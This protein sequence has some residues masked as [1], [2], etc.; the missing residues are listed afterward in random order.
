MEYCQLTQRERYAMANM[1]HR[2]Y[3]YRE[4]ARVLDRSVSTISRE[5]KRNMTHHDGR[6]RAEKAH[7]YAMARRSRTRRKSQY[8]QQEWAEVARLLMRKWSP[9]QIAGRARAMRTS[10]M[11]KETIYRYVKRERSAGGQT[12]QQLRILSKFGR[13]RRGSPATRGRL[14]GKR[15][16]SER[17]KAV[18]RRRQIGHWEGDTVMGADMRHC[19]LTL[20]ERVT[21][22]VIIKKLVARNKEQAAAALMQAIKEARRRVRTITLDNGTEFH[23]YELVEAKHPVKFYFAT[24]YHSWER[25]TN[26]N[27][28]GLIRQ[29]LPKGMCMRHITQADCDVIAAELNDRPRQRLGFKTPRE[30]FARS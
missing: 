23:D 6:Y 17:P 25:G 26:E 12:W 2:G 8:V 20:V 7:Q 21:G 3:S 19:V 4:I 15:H 28:N 22:Y 24:P 29:Y 11:S 27:T 1:M 5:K 14:V 13:K 16:I 9:Q 10:C 30:M 18:E